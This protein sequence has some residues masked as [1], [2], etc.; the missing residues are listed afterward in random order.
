MYTLWNN[1]CTKRNDW[2]AGKFG[3]LNMD[4]LYKAYRCKN[5]C[6]D[7]QTNSHGSRAANVFTVF[8][9]HAKDNQNKGE[10]G[11][12]F[13]AEAL[14]RR[15]S[16]MHH[17]HT[18]SIVE[19]GRRES[20]IM[21]T[22]KKEIVTSPFLVLG[23]IQATQRSALRLFYTRNEYEEATPGHPPAGPPWLKAVSLL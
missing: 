14:R 9:T 16:R 19:V 23:V 8:V 4:T 15:K 10:R 2:A 13:N 12:E 7:A 18:E 20:L 3:W 21:Y 22:Q 5:G 1:L 6:R 17:R 11:K